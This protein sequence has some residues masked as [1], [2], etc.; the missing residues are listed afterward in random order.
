MAG[1]MLLLL[2][3]L[4]ALQVR[5]LTPFLVLGVG[6][7]FFVHE[8]GI[9]ATIAGVLLALTIPT[10][11]RINAAQF[12]AKAPIVG[13]ERATEGVMAPLVRLEHAIHGFSA[14]VVMP[15]FAFSNAGVGLHGS[16]GGGVPL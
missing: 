12:S 6:L 13:L 1:L 7:W 8:S 2:I 9:H 14:F 10:R 15:L 4:N 3:A 5:R 11:T 16:L